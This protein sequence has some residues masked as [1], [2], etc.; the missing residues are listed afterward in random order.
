MTKQKQK[1]TRAT[2]APINDEDAQVVG[3]FFTELAERSKVDDIR[4]LDPKTA[5]AAVEKTPKN[6]P[7]RRVY[8]WNEKDAA[9]KFWIGFTR[10]LLNSVRV[11]AVVGN[12]K[13]NVPVFV[14]ADTKTRGDSVVTRRRHIIRADVVSHNAE[15]MSAVGFKI[16][17]IINGV[18]QVEHLIADNK[19]VLRGP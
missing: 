2:G 7:I 6:H 4:S 12:V 3:E 10:T 14:L 15:L 8:N 1:F 19:G 18:E 13:K 11:V 9:R 16:R 17:T 5:F